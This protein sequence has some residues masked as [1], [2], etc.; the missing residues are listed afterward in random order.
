[1][2][3]TPP[4]PIGGSWS[5]DNPLPVVQVTAQPPNVQHYYPPTVDNPIPVYVVRGNLVVD[6][7]PAAPEQ[8]AER[9]PDARQYIEE[10]PQDGRVYARRNGQW[11]PIGVM[12]DG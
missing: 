2:S 3:G 12:S 6:P 4:G 8:P 10:A 5:E 1:M 9:P 7:R 11:V